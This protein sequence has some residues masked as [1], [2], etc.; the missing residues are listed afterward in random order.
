V[1]ICF[2]TSKATNGF[3]SRIF[4]WQKEEAQQLMGASGFNAPDAVPLPNWLKTNRASQGASVD[5]WCR[6]VDEGLPD[7]PDLDELRQSR[8]THVSQIGS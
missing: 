5:A 7:L 4:G 6:F 2:R 1:L 8:Q 3:W